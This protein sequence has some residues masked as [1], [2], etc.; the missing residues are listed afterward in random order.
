MMSQRIQI[1]GINAFLTATYGH[2]T[3]LIDL[4]AHLHFDHQQLDSIRTEYLQDVINAYTGAVQEQVVADRD[5]ARLYQILVRRF[6]FDGNPADTLR[7]IAKNYGVSRERI[8]QL[9]QKAL[10]MCASKA[11]RGA[12]ETLLRD[13]VAKLVGGPQEPVEAT[14]A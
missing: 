11:I 5:G 10:K 6:G 3:R 12:I 4:L 9:E 2:D 13:A 1:V 7:D 14:T 8:R